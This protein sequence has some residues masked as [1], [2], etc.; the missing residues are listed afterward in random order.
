MKITEEG[1]DP[2]TK[3]EGGR[4][5][6]LEG[7]D[8][9]SNLKM[10]TEDRQLKGSNAGPENKRSKEYDFYIS[11]MRKEI[12]N[13]EE[14]SVAAKR[15]KK[16][17]A[18][19]KQNFKDLKNRQQILLP[20]LNEKQ[21]SPVEENFQ[22]C[23]QEDDFQ[24]GM[25]TMFCE[26]KRN[27]VTGNSGI[28]TSEEMCG[29]GH[30]WS[31]SITNNGTGCIEIRSFEEM[32]A[33][34]YQESMRTR[35]STEGCYSVEADNST[36]DNS[37]HLNSIQEIIAR[38]QQEVQLHSEIEV[39]ED[40]LEYAVEINEEEITEDGDDEYFFPTPDEVEAA[41]APAVG[42]SFKSIDEAHRYVNVYR[43]LA[44]FSVIKGRNYKHRKIN[45]QCNQAGNQKKMTIHKRRGKDMS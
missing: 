45:L 15:S 3:E 37:M 28:R 21:D 19:L 38:V 41:K 29:E 4:T 17:L 42:M 44:G 11:V 22:E 8:S 13:E 2:G 33:E 1:H 36:N 40:I 30:Q 14:D 39:V 18:S 7:C 43:Q 9:I 32:F 35:E 27:R 24:D 20:D 23:F 31:K 25:N 5:N 12:T 10:V 16:M 6:P 34:D 26:P